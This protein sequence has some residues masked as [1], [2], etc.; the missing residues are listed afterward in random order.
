[1]RKDNREKII[2]KRL[3]PRTITLAGM[4]SKLNRV[5]HAYELR[6]LL[7]VLAELWDGMTATERAERDQGATLGQPI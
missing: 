5:G 7:A 4:V 1:M 2:E 3:G 6:G